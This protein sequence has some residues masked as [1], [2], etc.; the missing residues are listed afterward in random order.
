M[1]HAVE[2]A[3]DAQPAVAARL[4]AVELIVAA[5]TPA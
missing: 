1:R 3:F 4:E 5:D 2:A